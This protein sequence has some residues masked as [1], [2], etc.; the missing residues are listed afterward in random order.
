MRK[1]LLRPRHTNDESITL[2]LNEYFGSD[3]TKSEAREII[4]SLTEYAQVLIE[5]WRELGE[6]DLMPD[7]ENRRLPHSP[8][9]MR[10]NNP[11]LFT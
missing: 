7:T 1:K 6:P 8:N 5:I 4:H 9:R 2:R 10:G 11:R 3:L